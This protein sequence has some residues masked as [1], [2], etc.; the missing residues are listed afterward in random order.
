MSQKKLADF[1][2]IYQNFDINVH[3]IDGYFDVGHDGKKYS[4][5]L[6]LKDM[7]QI[8]NNQ[9][10]GGHSPHIWLDFK[11]LTKENEK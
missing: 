5:G 8:T 7:L 3:F 1:K 10:G 11:N 6:N 4:I 2:N 9:N